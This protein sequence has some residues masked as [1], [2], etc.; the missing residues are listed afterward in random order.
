MHKIFFIVPLALVVS[1]IPMTGF[2]ADGSGSEGGVECA[3]TTRVSRQDIQSPIVA[4][5]PL[6]DL[7]VQGP[8]LD[9]AVEVSSCSDYHPCETVADCPCA[10]PDCYCVSSSTSECDFDRLCLCRTECF[11]GAQP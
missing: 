5:S 7:V 9:G 2:A 10:E 6:L 1:V 11:G 3:D 4:S 8:A